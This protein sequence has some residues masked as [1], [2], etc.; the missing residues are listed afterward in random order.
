MEGVSQNGVAA[1]HEAE[2]LEP[3]GEERKNDTIRGTACERGLRRAHGR[4]QRQF[5]AGA[6][7]MGSLCNLA[8]NLGDDGLRLCKPVEMLRHLAELAARDEVKAAIAPRS[9]YQLRGAG[10]RWRRRGWSYA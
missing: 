2:S 9:L 5:A 3:G 1:P 4:E 10:W 6:F 8:L 7:A